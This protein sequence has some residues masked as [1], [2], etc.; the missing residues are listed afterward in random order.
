M[1]GP[2]CALVSDGGLPVVVRQ[3]LD[4]RTLPPTARAIMWYLHFVLDF[5]VYREQKAESVAAGVGIDPATASRMLALL[6]SR[7]YLDEHG[8]QRPRA[9]RMPWS[10]RCAAERAA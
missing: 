3:A 1:S 5:H 9:F 6:V 10:R 4:D 7:G 8:K 2:H